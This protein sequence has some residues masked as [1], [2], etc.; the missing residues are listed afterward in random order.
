MLYNTIFL[1]CLLFSTIIILQVLQPYDCVIIR[2][3]E[4]IQSTF[5]FCLAVMHSK[6]STEKQ[7]LQSEEQSGLETL[8]T[9]R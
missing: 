2:F 8:T 3:V 4:Q 5:K 1:T 9:F 7:K 6:P